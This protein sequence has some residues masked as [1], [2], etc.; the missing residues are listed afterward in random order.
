MTRDWRLS[1]GNL[2]PCVSF[3]ARMNGFSSSAPPCALRSFSTTKS[4]CSSATFRAITAESAPL[5]AKY[6]IWGCVVTWGARDEIHMGVG[7]VRLGLWCRWRVC[8]VYSFIMYIWLAQLPRL[9]LAEE[10]F[11]ISAVWIGKIP[12]AFCISCSAFWI[13]KH[14]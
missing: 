5:K 12:G 1:L 8:C 3:T 4:E 7:T 6:L 14:S 10:P 11:S 13:L 2:T 9:G